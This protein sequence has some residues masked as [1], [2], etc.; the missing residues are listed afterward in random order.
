MD[1]TLI[2]ILIVSIMGVLA[3]RFFTRRK[4]PVIKEKTNMVELGFLPIPFPEVDFKQVIIRLHHK[5]PGQ[6]IAVA[7]VYQKVIGQDY[8][9]IL[10]VEDQAE[11]E[12]FFL[13][14]DMVAIRSTGLQMPRMTFMTR[15]K[16]MGGVGNLMDRFVSHHSN[17]A[18]NLQGLIQINYDDHPEIS[19]RYL[20][21]T[22][23]EAEGTVRQYLNENR[24]SFLGRMENNYV[25]DTLDDTLTVIRA[26]GVSSGN[27]QAQIEQSVQDAISLVEVFKTETAVA[28]G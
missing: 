24:L 8:V 17:W 11:K 2:I 28:S 10:D 22:T 21:F 3:F 5:Y 4:K 15:L 20:V 1:F 16:T 7:D 27:Q 26:V 25:I 9:Y 14:R 12:S 18:S 23:T 19:Q 13:A 6:Q